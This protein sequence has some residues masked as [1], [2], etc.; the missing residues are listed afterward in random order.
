MAQRGTVCVLVLSAA[1][2]VG[3]GR[4]E[5]EMGMRALTATEEAC[6]P[7]TTGRVLSGGCRSIHGGSLARGRL[8][9]KEE[10]ILRL[11]GGKEEEDEKEE[12]RGR[13]GLRVSSPRK[14]A[15]NAGKSSGREVVAE[16][17]APQ[18]ISCDV[19]LL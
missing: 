15:R 2:L 7:P 19:M 12:G 16:K 17:V 4:G 6:M 18:G 1:V 3:G 10:R 9:L 13:E 8:L 14:K 11:R 5:R